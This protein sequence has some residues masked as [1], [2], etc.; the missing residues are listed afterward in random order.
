MPQCIRAE[1]RQRTV[2]RTSFFT[3]P[4]TQNALHQ[5]LCPH[6]NHECFLLPPSKLQSNLV[7]SLTLSFYAKK[8]AFFFLLQYRP[9][10]GALEHTRQE[11]AFPLQAVPVVFATQVQDVEGISGALV[12]LPWLRWSLVYSYSSLQDPVTFPYWADSLWDEVW[13]A[14]IPLQH[15][16]LC[17]ALPFADSAA[18]ILRTGSS[19]ALHAPYHGKGSSLLM[20]SP[21]MHFLSCHTP[22][23]TWRSVPR[24]DKKSRQTHRPG[25]C[26]YNTH[27]TPRK[28]SLLTTAQPP[29]GLRPFWVPRCCTSSDIVFTEQTQQM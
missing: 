19:P 16:P 26:F 10:P 21:A 27:R 22:Q 25:L 17:E 2:S 11:R 20:L 14:G 8:R 24:G 1:D 5:P 15:S 3:Q 12:I 28:S 4:Y 13:P 29:Q 9:F 18:C 6:T 23:W 7:V